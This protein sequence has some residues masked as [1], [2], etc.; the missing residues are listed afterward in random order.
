MRLYIL[1]TFLLITASFTICSTAADVLLLDDNNF[2]SVT[3]VQSPT[4]T[5]EP[6]LIE[7][8]APWCGHCNRLESTYNQLAT[9]LKHQVHVGK[10]DGTVAKLINS[11]YGVKGFPT[12]K[13]FIGKQIIDYT[14]DR[15]LNSLHEFATSHGTI[16]NT[17]QPTE[18]TKDN[19]IGHAIGTVGHTATDMK[20]NTNNGESTPIKSLPND[21]LH[22]FQL[23]YND[24]KLIIT[25]KTHA[26]IILFGVGIF[27]GILMPL[28]ISLINRPKPQIN[29]I[30]KQ[31]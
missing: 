4:G 11:R 7:F 20:A 19:K 16:T 27:I 12:I 31:Q 10:I 6:Y 17:V 1:I 13:L 22:A 18:H 3:G 9:K 21:I 29:S 15:S 28:L 30:K 26:A 5:T 14:G 25:A 2:D 24:I 23:L 8:Y